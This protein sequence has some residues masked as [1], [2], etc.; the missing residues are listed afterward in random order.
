MTFDGGRIDYS[1]F[2]TPTSSF[3]ELLRRVDPTLL[4]AGVPG[5]RPVPAGMVPHATTI[6]ALRTADGVVMAGDRRGTMGNLIASRDMV[7]VFPADHSSL[8]GFA[9]TAGVGIEFVRLF[10]VEIEHYEKIEGVELS[11]DGKANRLSAMVRGNIGA[12]MQG[13]VAIPIFAGFDRSTG[14]GRVFGLDVT[15]TLHEERDYGSIG[16][17]SLFAKAALKKLYRPEPSTP[18]AVAL[19]I[20]ALYDAADDDSATGGPDPI[21]KIYPVVMTAT[22][23]GVQRLEDDRVAALV[24]EMMDDLPPT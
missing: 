15:G 4:P 10:Q 6:V 21:R 7:K 14:T 23:D 19:A 3:T 9:G 11:L 12:A 17:G 1:V 24:G 20:R 5:G 8:I 22:A 16:S 2:F 13:L 18:D